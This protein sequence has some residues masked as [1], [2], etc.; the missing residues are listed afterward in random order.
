VEPKKNKNPF[1]K[2]KI[3]SEQKWMVQ[4]AIQSSKQTCKTLLKRFEKKGFTF[5]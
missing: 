2:I 3:A 5:G 4:D 1:L